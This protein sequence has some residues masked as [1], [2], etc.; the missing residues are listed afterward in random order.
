MH[1]SPDTYSSIHNRKRTDRT[2]THSGLGTLNRI[3]EI[4]ETCTG[5]QK[6]V[7]ACHC[8]CRLFAKDVI[9]NVIKVIFHTFGLGSF[10]FGEMKNWKD[11][12]A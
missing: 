8:D 5:T 6:K 2:G 9:P 12:V 4:G 10:L 11:V 3:P 7:R 1:L